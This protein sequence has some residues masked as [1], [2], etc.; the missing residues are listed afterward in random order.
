MSTYFGPG[1][2]V[3]DLPG[4]PDEKVN[5]ADPM[6]GKWEGFL[7]HVYIYIYNFLSTGD[8]SL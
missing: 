6:R 1:N 3:C 4:R 7:F 8:A 2:D 5:G